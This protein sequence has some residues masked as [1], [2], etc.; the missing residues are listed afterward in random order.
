MRRGPLVVDARRHLVDALYHL[1]RAR[2]P[3]ALL[4]VLVAA[5]RISDVAGALD[6]L[7][8]ALR[9]K[10]ET[11]TRESPPDDPIDQRV[12]TANSGGPCPRFDGQ[13]DPPR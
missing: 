13:Q 9:P 2:Y 7:T 5:I 4:S 12:A 10:G 11:R 6:G 1:E 8:A 3:E